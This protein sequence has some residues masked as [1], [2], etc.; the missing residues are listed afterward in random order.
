MDISPKMLEI[1][2]KKTHSCGITTIEFVQGSIDDL[3]GFGDNDFDLVLCL[4]SPLSFCYNTY[5]TA[6]S[7]LVRVT[8][9]RL[10]LCV[11]N[12]LGVIPEG[13]DFDLK[14]FGKLKTVLEVYDTGTL[15]VTE[16]FKR[17][18]PTFFQAGTPSH[19]TKSK[20]C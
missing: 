18:Q 13:V 9:S 4:D 3:S 17:L 16:E 7:E 8:K 10:V 15:V 1:A 14:H 20:N 5:E 19:Q 11:I 2:R 12:R 6:L